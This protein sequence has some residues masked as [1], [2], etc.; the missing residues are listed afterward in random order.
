MDGDL[1]KE[2][3]NIM[4]GVEDFDPRLAEEELFKQ[5]PG[6]MTVTNHGDETG[7]DAV[8]EQAHSH[9]FQ[10]KVNGSMG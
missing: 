1:E 6:G 9:G 3:Q 2:L 10:F 7:H 8:L 4:R 5:A